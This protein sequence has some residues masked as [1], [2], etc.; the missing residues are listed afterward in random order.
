MDIYLHIGTPKTGTTSLQYSL[1]AAAGALAA[2]GVLYPDPQHLTGHHLVMALARPHD[3]LPTFLRH[4]PKLRGTDIASLA[5]ETLA[6]WKAEIDRTRPKAVVLTS[7]FLCEL[8][9]SDE[10]GALHS[11]LA[12]LGGTIR[13]VIYVRDPADFFL[14][15][16]Q[17][18]VKTSGKPLVYDDPG[19]VALIDRYA[20]VLG[21]PVIVR[22]FIRRSLKDG[23]IVR[24][25]LAA[26]VGA[27]VPEGKVPTIRRNESI[28]A[29]AMSILHAFQRDGERD[30]ENGRDPSAHAFRKL[31]EEVE[32]EAG[33]ARAP[34][35]LPGLR[36][37]IYRA[38]SDL[39]PLRARFGIEFE[40]VDYA[41]AGTGTAADVV[42]DGTV[43][44]MIDVD[45][46]RREMIAQR[47]FRK[48][49]NR[50]AALYS[51]FVDVRGKLVQARQRSGP[52]RA[53]SLA[54]R[55]RR[56]LRQAWTA[57]D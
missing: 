39:Q 38:S 32:A 1:R 22:P 11:A 35:L 27:L 18:R 21:V 54:V 36:A 40:G 13:P 29:E 34:R 55:V 56:R 9:R 51:S 16:R 31:L 23:D 46:L 2:H 37:A 17:Q 15:S 4:N 19:F 12:G 10:I 42:L 14:S 52:P 20:A 26:T 24:D 6:G 43:E 25:F 44:G 7:E 50:E 48:I 41:L 3:A 5:A 28:S 8:A 45:P 47:A 33:N 53:E 57:G 49:L 30:P